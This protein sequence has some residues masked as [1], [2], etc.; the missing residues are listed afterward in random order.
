MFS[1]GIFIALC[2]GAIGTG[3]LFCGF[4]VASSRNPEEQENFFS[5]T[6]IGFALIE[7][8]IFIGTL[9]LVLLFFF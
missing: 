1:I 4:L 2:G 9:I 7:S 5:Y 3:V 6:L 8:Y